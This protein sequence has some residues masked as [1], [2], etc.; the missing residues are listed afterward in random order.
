MKPL[1]LIF[2][3]ILLISCYETRYEP[4]NKTLDP[5]IG[6]SEHEVILRLGPPTKTTD[7]GAGGHIIDYESTFLYAENELNTVPYDKTLT[8][9]TT[10]PITHYLQ[11]YIDKTGIIYK[12][13]TNL[14][15]NPIKVKRERPPRRRPSDLFSHKKDTTKT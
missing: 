11:F 10:I 4:V 9:T 3:S 7:D 13:R 5:Y 8:T 15:G 2:I 12:W 6:K 14:Q 1:L